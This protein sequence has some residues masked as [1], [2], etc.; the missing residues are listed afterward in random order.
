MQ[1]ADGPV[2]HDH[3]VS[4]NPSAYGYTKP[5]S[6]GTALSPKVPLYLLIPTISPE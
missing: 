1:R 3:I 4:Q 6:I 5:R 2:N